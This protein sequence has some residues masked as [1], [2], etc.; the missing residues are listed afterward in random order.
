MN[1]LQNI[2]ITAARITSVAGNDIQEVLTKINN[3]MNYATLNH[4]YQVKAP[5]ENKL[6]HPYIAAIAD[7][8]LTQTLTNTLADLLSQADLETTLLHTVL[9]SKSDCRSVYINKTLIQKL[10]PQAQLSFSHAGQGVC[11]QLQNLINKLHNNEYQTIIFGGIDSLTDSNTI[12]EFGQQTRIMSNFG[13]RGLVPSEAAAY[14]VLQIFNTNTTI[15]AIT[16]KPEP[17]LISAIQQTLTR[18]KLTPKAITTTLSAFGAEPNEP[19]EWADTTQAIW[20]FKIYPELPNSILTYRT[21][22]EIGAATIPLQLALTTAL[23]GNSLICEA[24]AYPYRGAILIHN[25]PEKKNGSDNL[26]TNP[27]N[28]LPTKS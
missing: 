20:P 9:P 12:K 15:K 6:Y 19:L 5:G 28:Q 3:N 16:H 14:V 11:L 2:S 18:T 10:V 25:K 24:N 26:K 13:G 17:N 8:D 27:P 4:N 23:P 1:N 21:L 7:Y 22:G